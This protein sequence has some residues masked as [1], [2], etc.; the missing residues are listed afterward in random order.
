[1]DGGVG[2]QTIAAINAANPIDLYNTY[3]S[4]RQNFYNNIAAND[5][6]QN[7]FINGWTTRVNSFKNKLP[8]FFKNVKLYVITT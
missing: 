6:T 4:N 3:K 7:K 5:P 2:S 1:V 8:N